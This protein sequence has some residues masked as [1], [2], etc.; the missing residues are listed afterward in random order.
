MSR[1]RDATMAGDIMFVN[2]IPFF[3]TISR[4]I[5]FGMAEM[6]TSEKATMLLTAIKYVH[7]SY[8]MKCGFKT[9]HILLDKQFEPIRGDSAALGIT[10]YICTIKEHTRCV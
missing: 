7:S 6:I 9:M 1:Y 2:K 3:M 5:K 10:L 8:Y 4:D